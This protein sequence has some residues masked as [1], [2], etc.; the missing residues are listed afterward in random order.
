VKVSTKGIAGS[1]KKHMTVFSNDPDNPQV[2][3]AIRGQIKHYVALHP[4]V[5]NFWGTPD[6]KL[7]RKVDIIPAKEVKLQIK[8]VRSTV[9]NEV[10]YT[11]AAGE[12]EGEYYLTVENIRTIPGR[13]HGN[14]IME[15]N[16]PEKPE[17]ILKVYGNIQKAGSIRKDS[18]ASPKRSEKTA[19]DQAD[20]QTKR[21]GEGGMK[22]GDAPAEGRH[23]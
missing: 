1:V 14:I 22:Q 19:T 10:K 21:K 11:L 18:G 7:V 3:L 4:R 6:R 12:K 5:V 15:T 20:N 8:K 23:F 9:S 17:L 16:L 13:Y 2:A